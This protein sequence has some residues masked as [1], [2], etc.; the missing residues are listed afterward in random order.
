[1]KHLESKGLLSV[2]LQTGNI[3]LAKHRKISETKQLFQ[4]RTRGFAVFDCLTGFPK[5]AANEKA[6]KNR[7]GGVRSPRSH[8]ARVLGSTQLPGKFL[9]GDAAHHA[10]VDD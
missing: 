4:E 10:M 9:L 8:L 3:Y 1:M 2:S 7:A 6:L 5:G